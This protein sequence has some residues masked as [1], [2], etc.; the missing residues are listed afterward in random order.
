[1]KWQH[2]KDM[3][4]PKCGA[5]LKWS[6]LGNGNQKRFPAYACTKCDFKISKTKFESVVNSLYK[7]RQPSTETLSED[8]RLS[9]LNNY[10]RKSLYERGDL[11]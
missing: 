5:A 2:L 7:G 11:E 1:M 8:Q 9:E 3:L 10:G 4:C 6:A